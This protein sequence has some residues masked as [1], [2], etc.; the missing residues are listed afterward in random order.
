MKETDALKDSVN[1]G[2]ELKVAER[3]EEIRKMNEV[4]KEH[5]IQLANKAEDASKARLFQENMSYE[6]FKSIFADDSA[7]A[8][9]LS[10]LKWGRN[11]IYKCK[12]CGYGEYKLLEN[13]SR[14]CRSCNYIESPTNGTL[15]FN[16]KFSL[17]K[18]FY[19]T[20]L[21]STGTKQLSMEEISKQID[22][23]TGTYWKFHKKVEETMEAFK[24]SKKRKDGNWTQLIEFSIE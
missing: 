17:H 15:F 8:T 13:Y 2:L 7:C 1:R 21:T 14:R 4:L 23:R 5:N 11:K 12:K 16:T 22:L 24:K 9:Y 18:A 20:Y 10:D 19:I 6:E 3:T